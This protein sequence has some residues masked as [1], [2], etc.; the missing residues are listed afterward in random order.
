MYACF[1]E[2]MVLGLIPLFLGGPTTSRI[3]RLSIPRCE[4]QRL[5]SL[6][7]DDHQIFS[8]FPS[9][10]PS[11]FS[12]PHWAYLDVSVCRK[13]F[14]Y[15]IFILIPVFIQA[16]NSFNATLAKAAGICFALVLELYLISLQV[17][18][19]LPPPLKQQVQRLRVQQVQRLRVHPLKQQVQRLRAHL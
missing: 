18:L 6:T 15:K 5:R 11:G 17:V 9:P 12:V 2:G 10:I 16:G 4:N 7:F 14:L 8:R 19:I 3:V 1:A 13:C